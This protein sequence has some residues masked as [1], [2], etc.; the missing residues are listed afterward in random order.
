ML[1]RMALEE[2]DADTLS[3]TSIDSSEFENLKLDGTSAMSSVFSESS[4][5]DRTSLSGESATSSSQ[6]GGKGERG[7]SF[8]KRSSSHGSMERQ[9]K[10]EDSLA[11]WLSQGT[12]IYKSVGLGLMDLAVGLHLVKV[13]AA[14]NVGSHI[15]GFC[16]A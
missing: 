5:T 1:R 12:V 6:N 9:R 11:R 7:F 15:N 14:R 16:K 3:T 2:S 13:A 10:K 8:H 4:S